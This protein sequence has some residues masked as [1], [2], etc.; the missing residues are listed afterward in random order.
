MRS[1]NPFTGEL[2]RETLHVSRYTR[3]MFR[4]MEGRHVHPSTLSAMGTREQCDRLQGALLILHPQWLP[5][6]PGEIDA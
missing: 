2:Y 5:P 1:L 4:L 6:A 3:A